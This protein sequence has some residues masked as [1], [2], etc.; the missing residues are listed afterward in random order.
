VDRVISTWI[1][2]RFGEQGDA[3][4]NFAG[5]GLFIYFL[6]CSTQILFRGERH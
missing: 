3:V 5:S 4:F 6:C 2:E 1:H